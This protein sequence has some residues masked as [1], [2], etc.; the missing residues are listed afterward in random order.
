[1]FT[2][3]W[4][5]LSCIHKLVETIYVH[6]FFW[7]N[8]QLPHLLH[9]KNCGNNFQY[10]R[11]QNFIVKDHVI[12]TQTGNVLLI[13]SQNLSYMILEH[14][15]KHSLAWFVCLFGAQHQN[16]RKTGQFTQNWT[17]HISRIECYVRKFGDIWDHL[18]TVGDKNK[19]EDVWF[20]QEATREINIHLIHIL[21]YDNQYVSCRSSFIFNYTIYGHSRPLYF[22]C[23]L[24]SIYYDPALLSLV[25]MANAKWSKSEPSSSN[26]CSR[27]L[28]KKSHHSGYHSVHRKHLTLIHIWD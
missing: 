8:I 3:K 1:M 12:S 22:H 25:N 7:L 23:L 26:W 6:L 4:A 28:K 19:I 14:E 16:N 20:N 15:Y 10:A 27:N 9:W 17:W 24:I 13:C 21:T 5:Y 11:R 2:Q 18:G